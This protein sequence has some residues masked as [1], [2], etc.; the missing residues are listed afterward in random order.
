M[1]FP[2]LRGSD[3]ITLRNSSKK[4]FRSTVFFVRGTFFGCLALFLMLIFCR[5]ESLS[6]EERFSNASHN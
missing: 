1:G 2:V 6:V 4:A 3:V 5:L